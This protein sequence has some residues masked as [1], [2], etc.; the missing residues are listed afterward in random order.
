MKVRE[1]S[2]SRSNFL[3]VDRMRDRADLARD[4]SDTA[5]FFDLLYLGEMTIK[6]LVVELLAA[7]QQDRERQ[8][9]SLEYRLVRADGLGEWAEVLDQALT[10]PASHHLVAEGRESQRTLTVVQG[11]NQAGW[12]HEAVM[13]LNAA[14]RCVESGY[15]D[16]SGQRV[17]LR[18][19]VHQFVWLRNRTRGHGAV[20]AATVSTVCPRLRDSIDAVVDN[21]PAFRRSWAYLRRSLS[22]K[23]KVS[24]FGGDRTPFGYLA[25]EANH[26][27]ADG[28]YVALDQPRPADLLFTDTDLTDFLLPNGNFKDEHFEV[29]S[30]ITDERRTEEG[31][32][33]VLPTHAQPASETAAE[34]ALDLVGNVFTNI[35]PRRE[36][37]V[38]R[39]A[40]ESELARVLRDE[41]HPVITLHG[42]GGVGKTSLTL[43]VLHELAQTDDFFAIIWFSARDIDLLQ[44]GPS[45][46]RPD[47]LSTEDIAR[48]FSLLMT[49]APDSKLADA[50]QYFTNCL[51]GDADDGPFLFVLD[52]FETIR[53]QAELYS[54]LDNAVRL[55]NKVLITTRTRDF[56]ADYPIEVKGMTR[57]EFALLVAETAVRLGISD[58]IDAPYEDLLFHESD[59]HPY[60][61]K[62]LL[63]E[64][65]HQKRQVDVKR[66]VAAKDALLDA[67]F[68]R[69]FATLAPASQRVFL[70]LCSWRSL[71]PRV[72][73]EAV[74]LRPGN[75]ERL[76]VGR[77]LDELEQSSLVELVQ[78]GETT[79]VYVSVPLAASTFGKKKMVTSPLKIAIEADLELIR[80]FGSTTTTD[81][82]H[83]LGPRIDRLAKAAATRAEAGGDL[84]Q[85]LAVIE[86]VA[87]KYAP[88]WLALAEL[89]RDQ[90]D[91]VA[92]AI[93][94][95]NR[96]LE[97]RPDD[98]DGWSRLIRLHRITGDTL[99]EMHARLQLAD[100]EQPAF[101]D[102]S[103]TASRL[104]GLLHRREIQLD[105]DERRLMI[106]KLRRLMEPRHDEADA[107][108]LSRLA[109]LCIHD[110]DEAAAKRW[111][112][113]GLRIEPN[114]QHCLKLKIRLEG[115]AD[116]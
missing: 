96:Y 71:V 30:Y 95:T 102:L 26:S 13:L 40:L 83:G 39:G 78:D 108:D 107:T 97:S 77:A 34:P 85:D 42:R 4:E 82:S 29:L 103:S 48:D 5:Y 87:T 52:N 25:R 53:D 28:V 91:D 105:A 99:A 80:G 36:A 1:G 47:V 72:G 14:C 17:S 93:R 10:G 8:R 12:Q 56:K 7:M 66:V 41:R 58:L 100:L 112:T 22:G 61:A 32:K 116:G 110:H 15:D 37:F 113:E 70:T 18:Q 90:L 104:N 88:A 23:Y 19:W 75:E 60:I 63:G 62:V 20:K 21:S 115:D 33:Y 67:L 89:L 54:Y 49:G 74:L 98:R 55:P 101:S 73:L 76:D 31:A 64:V 111:T 16:L 106:S 57:D 65:A 79:E 84:T 68:D 35:P 94:A 9:Y 2:I 69:T 51:S 27:L 59:G 43:E 45:V 86:Y 11:V 3:P 109:W 114:N 92:G 38:H 44:K 81:L 6:L 46:V 24:P 50:T